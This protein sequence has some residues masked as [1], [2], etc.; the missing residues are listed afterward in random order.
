MGGYWAGEMSADPIPEI[1][2]HGT[3]FFPD[4]QRPPFGLR[5]P[6]NSTT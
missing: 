1:I 4:W 6:A 3:I 5:K 2:V